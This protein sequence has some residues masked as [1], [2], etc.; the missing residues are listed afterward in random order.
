MTDNFTEATTEIAITNA[1]ALY[2]VFS[3]AK[4]GEYL[5]EPGNIL[6][7]VVSVFAIGFT[8]V[9]TSYYLQQ[10]QYAKEDREELRKSKKP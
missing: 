1:A 4:W 10:K 5:G 7:L 2:V 6:S 3:S 9:R 8:I